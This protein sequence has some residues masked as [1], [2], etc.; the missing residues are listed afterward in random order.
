MRLAPYAIAALM[1][2]AAAADLRADE[3]P[4]TRPGGLVRVDNSK[5]KLAYVRPGTDWSK[6]RSLKLEPLSIPVA[7][8]DAAPPSGVHKKFRES[9]VLGDKE[10][11]AIRDAYDKT[12]RDVLGKG[13][14]TFVETPQADTLIVA[15]QVM[16]IKLNAPIESTRYNYSGR[17]RTYSQGG[18]SVVVGAVFADGA[19][20]DVIAEA[21]DR[22]YPTPNVWR[23]NNAVSNLAEL[24]QAFARWARQLRDKLNE[25]RAA[26][27]GPRSN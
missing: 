18:G 24:R 9:F 7:V 5:V 15:A 6:Y 26:P 17:G 12:M 1:I 13:G 11:A 2:I 22:S 20:G 16:D 23:V 10:V 14:F 3:P 21:V 19:T 25:S 27:P 4:A 8:R